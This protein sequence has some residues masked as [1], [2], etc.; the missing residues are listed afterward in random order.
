MSERKGVQ[1]D[2]L[3][4]SLSLSRPTQDC[5]VCTTVQLSYSILY[6]KG[7]VRN[8]PRDTYPSPPALIIWRLPEND[9]TDLY[10]FFQQET[11]T[12][13]LEDRPPNLYFIPSLPPPGNI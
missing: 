2:P 9:I 7:A 11:A 8:V 5:A 12:N 10:Y 6:G 4:L 3:S 13:S 1:L